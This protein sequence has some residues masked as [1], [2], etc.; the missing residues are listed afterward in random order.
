VFALCAETDAEAERL[1]A[2]IDLRRLQM[3]AGINGPIPTLAEALATPLSAAEKE[4][5]RQHRQRAVIGSPATVRRELVALRER[6]EADEV[7]V[8]TI[9]GDYP[10]RLRS[11]E[12]LAAEC[13]LAAPR[14]E[15]QVSGQGRPQRDTGARST[16][17]VP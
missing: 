3:D 2:S 13:G 5:I 17:A 10:S 6:Y 7:V 9:T 1:A 16:K 12:L 4:R 15:A 8:V 14:A 11:Y